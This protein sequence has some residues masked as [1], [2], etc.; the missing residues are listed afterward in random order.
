MVEPVSIR[1]VGQFEVCVGDRVVT[2][3]DWTRRR[4][5]ELVQLLALAPARSLLR[6]QVIDALWPHLDPDAGA[7]NLRKAAHHARQVLGS[8]EAVVLS[9]GQAQL[10]PGADVSVD[11]VRFLSGASEVLA[12]PTRAGCLDLADSV[13]GELLPGSLYEEWTIQPRRHF[14]ETRLELLREAGEWARVI[15]LDPVDEAAYQEL[16][17]EA[18][19]DGTRSVVIRRYAQV[20]DALA[21]EL[22]VRPDATTENLYEQAMV[23]LASDPIDLVGRDREL[24]LVDDALGSTSPAPLG[25]VVVRGPAGIGKTAFCGRVATLASDKGWSVRWTD[26]AGPD[27]AFGPL[28]PVIEEIMLAPDKSIDEVP[29]HARSV[30]SALTELGSVADPV[31]G[32]MTRH[33]VLG[34]IS[35]ALRAASS[36]RRTMLV[37]DDAHEADD[38]TV[39]VLAHMASSVPDVTVILAFRGE[40]ASEGLRSTASRLERSRRSLTVDLAALA[41]GDA[42]EL[43]RRI[44]P[45]EIGE[46]EIRRIVERSEGNPFAITELARHAGARDVELTRSVAD[47]ITARMIA[48]D[49]EALDALRRLALGRAELDIASVE[50]LTGLEEPASFEVLDAA[51]E[52]GVLVVAEGRYRF[53]HDLVREALESQLTPHLARRIHRSAAKRL[54][55][56]NASAATVA[57]HWLAAGDPASA[58]EWCI[59]AA[60]DAMRLGAFDDA[61]RHLAPVLAHDPH[62]PR[63]LRLEAESLDMLGDPRALVAYD[64]AIEVADEDVAD[65][66]VI[67]RA[68]AQI[69]QGDPAGGLASIKGA[70]PR[71]PMGRLNEALAYAGAAALGATDPALG[72]AKAAEVRR[73]ALESGDR[74]GIVIAAWAHAAAA[75]ARGELH[76]SVRFDLRETKDLPHLAV[77]VFDGHL[78]MTQRFLYGSRPYGEVI[79][80]A[81]DLTTEA[82]R[83]HAARGHAFGVT[84]R[85]EAMFLSGHLDEAR[86]GFDRALVLHRDTAGTTGEAH[87]LQRLAELTYAAGQQAEAEALI[88]QALELAR[89]SDIGFHLLDR[90]YGSRIHIRGDSGDALGTLE[91]AEAAVRGP[92]ETCPGCRIHFAVPAAIAAA[93]CGDLDRAHAYEQACDYLTNV[94][95]RLPAWYAAFDEVR[96]SVAA[97][98]GERDRAKALFSSAAEGYGKAGHPLDERRCRELLAAT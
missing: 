52:S 96:A 42:T 89:V 47:A 39:D 21:S 49:P 43:A 70:T 20:R 54:A 71:S 11:L 45:G 91:E 92:L 65:D 67:N 53:R 94:V 80:F 73:I 6:D 28:V 86:E 62:H 77:R 51:L 69:K 81:E 97:A 3:Q 79:S 33:Q 44:G 64:S 15:E 5:M 58:T 8:T 72:T 7:A 18:L 17:R 57:H 29:G 41:P 90:M 93:N 26:T 61:R 30:L 9:S 16:M 37:L 84:L 75:H 78:C 2:E 38:A 40:S 68:L 34:A 19:A 50:A 10:F 76:D 55:E 56:S 31:D 95:M 48:L 23:G 60:E 35:H 83:L 98:E 82:Q 74:S 87:A 24:A 36:G 85:A 32:P 25:A 66:L 27:R 63:G 88:D 1:L 4:A 14:R 22:G 46:E 13:H 12:S 59:A